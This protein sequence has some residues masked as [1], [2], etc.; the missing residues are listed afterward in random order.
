MTQA[1][2]WTHFTE[3][4][5]K[6]YIS[7][8][9]EPDVAAAFLA[10][11]LKLDNYR[12]DAR[13]A[14]LLDYASYA[15]EFAHKQGYGPTRTA[16]WYNVA[17][18]VLQTCISGAAYTECEAHFKGLMLQLVRPRP[19]TDTPHFSPDQVA[20]AAAFM[21]RGLL[22]HYRLYQHVFSTEQA[23]TEYT[24]ELMVET[25]VV[26]SFEAALAQADWD[27]L[28]EQRRAAAEAARQA[29][30]EAEAARLE[31]EAK[32]QAEEARRLA[33]EARRA[34]LARKPAT[35]E[36]AIEHLIA[37]RLE[38]EKE[39][40]AATYKAKEA[41]LLAKISSLEDTAAAKKAVPAAAGAKK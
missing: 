23:H 11:V 20:S 26:P 12:F 15:L 36:E 22:R 30:E 38:S 34:E 7:K 6:E 32:A 33:E 39:S 17:H 13:Q 4:E 10:S 14:I 25:P 29:A 27:A 24:A 18:G 41:E 35:L 19:G 2:L 1:D 3:D 37:T 28:H 16:S 9:S 5:L 8:L 31:A 21:A 40:L